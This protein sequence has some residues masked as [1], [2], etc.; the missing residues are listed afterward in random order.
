LVIGV[1]GHQKHTSVNKKQCCGLGLINQ[2][3]SDDAKAVEA[4]SFLK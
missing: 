4:N 2:L 1:I 3:I